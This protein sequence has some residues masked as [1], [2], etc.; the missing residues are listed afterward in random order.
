MNKLADEMKNIDWTNLEN[1]SEPYREFYE[2]FL[3]IFNNCC[4]MKQVKYDRN[5]NAIK[6]WMTDEILQKRREKFDAWKI[7]KE[8]KTKD[9]KINYNKARN[10][11]N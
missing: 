5:Y 7:L 11:L 3:P 6:S 9:N 8:S 10:I 4:P 1:S 2:T